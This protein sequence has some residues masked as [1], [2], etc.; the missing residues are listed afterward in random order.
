M[1]SRIPA[2]VWVKTNRA[3]IEWLAGRS[4]AGFTCVPSVIGH[5]PNIGCNFKV[6]CPDFF[7]RKN[8]IQYSKEKQVRSFYFGAKMRVIFSGKRFMGP[9]MTK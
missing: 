5:H 7:N 3:F 2:R 8:D 1:V 9:E 6:K 4:T